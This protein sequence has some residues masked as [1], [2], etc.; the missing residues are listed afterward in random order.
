[1]HTNLFREAITAHHAPINNAS[2]LVCDGPGWIVLRFPFFKLKLAG[3]VSNL[4]FFLCR[5]AGI[6]SNFSFLS[7]GLAE[8][9]A[10]F[11]KGKSA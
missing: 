3:I 11:L 4:L 1:M 5:L 9:V 6:V 8:I 10:V 7:V 2:C